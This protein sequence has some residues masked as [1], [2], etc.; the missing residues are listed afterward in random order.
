M[1]VSYGPECHCNV[2]YIITQERAAS[3]CCNMVIWGVNAVN[4]SEQHSRL[5]ISW[6]PLPPSKHHPIS[7]TELLS[8]L[9]IRKME[10]CHTV[11]KEQLNPRVWSS[12]CL[13]IFY[14]LKSKYP[15]VRDSSFWW[16]Y[17]IHAVQDVTKS[18][19]LE[20]WNKWDVIV[21]PS[22]TAIRE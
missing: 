20:T 12:I 2:T 22:F 4:T 3:L 19:W 6:T 8:Q 10:I 18:L 1:H 17:F 7:H 15:H 14:S 21:T 9:A 16:V 5:Q 13:S 11:T